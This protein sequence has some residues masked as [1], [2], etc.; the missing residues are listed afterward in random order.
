MENNL[1]NLTIGAF[2]KA[3]GVSAETIRFYQHKGLLPVPAK[4]YGGIRRY[5]KVDVQRVRFIKSAQRLGFSLSE[6]SE[7]LRLEDGTHCNEVYYLTEVK[8]KDVHKK[9]EELKRLEAALSALLHACHT[10]KDNVSC[11]IIASLQN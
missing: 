1:E 5:S 4:P 8:L 7:L 10:R 11:P 9:L 2:A 3:A 6:I